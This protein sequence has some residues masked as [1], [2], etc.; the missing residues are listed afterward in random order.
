MSHIDPI[1]VCIVAT[2]V[3]ALAAIIYSK[4]AHSAVTAALKE[5]EP[6]KVLIAA[7]AKKAK[8]EAETLA[9]AMAASAAEAAKKTEVEAKALEER[10]AALTTPE[11]KAV[12]DA[13]LKLEAATYALDAA[14]KKLKA[15]VVKV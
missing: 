5:L 10:I 1:T 9:L 7:A 14:A 13:K 2:F 15:D 4:Y 12:E 6:A 11:R 8:E 3:V